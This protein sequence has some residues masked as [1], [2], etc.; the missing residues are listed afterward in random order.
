MGQAK[1]REQSVR[2]SI[3]KHISS[4]MLSRAEGSPVAGMND[5][6]FFNDVISSPV[7]MLEGVIR[8][9][10]AGTKVIWKR[11]NQDPIK[12]L[13]HLAEQGDGGL[14]AGT[15]SWS[16]QAGLN[17]TENIFIRAEPVEDD[18]VFDDDREFFNSNPD[19]VS[20]VREAYPVEYQHLEVFHGAK[21]MTLVLRVSKET[22]NSPRIRFLYG[23][24]PNS[25]EAS[26]DLEDDDIKSMVIAL[27]GFDDIPRL[28]SNRR[29]PIA[30]P[31][32][33]T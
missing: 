11:G 29:L 13:D 10:D 15:I 30:M 12:F 19:R 3:R 2:E 5:D 27:S 9:L 7:V 26:T 14:L 20:R 6:D 17:E 8:D 23:C 31:D 28:M 22:T 21:M 16:F 24:N 18:S 25:R 32:I 4:G 33:E 1:R